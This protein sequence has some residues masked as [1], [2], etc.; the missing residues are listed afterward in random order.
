M[1]MSDLIQA[2]EARGRDNE[3][4]VLHAVAAAGADGVTSSETVA[5]T[6]LAERTVRDVI[7]RLVAQRLAVRATSRRVVA[8]PAGQAEAGAG[9]PGLAM[10]AAL[11]AALDL[12]P[13]EPMKAFVRLLLSGVVARHHL[14]WQLLAATGSVDGFASFVAAGPTKTGKTAMAKLVCQAFGLIEAQAIRTA[15]A[16]TEKSLWARRAPQPGGGYRLEPSDT[17]GRPFLCI[18]EF[19]KAPAELRSHLV[20]LAQGDALAAGEGDQLLEVAP[21]ALFCLNGSAD[22]V[23]EA[24]R[25]RS[26]V[27]DLNPLLPLLGDVH[28]A[29]R[30]LLGGA[31]PRLQLDWLAPPGPELADAEREL[32]LDGL[33][34]GLTEPGWRWADERAI[35]RLALGRA[36]L[37][38]SDPAA[39]AAATVADYL[40]CARTVGEARPGL[41]AVLAARLAGSSSLLPVPVRAEAELAQRANAS[42]RRQAEEI[43]LVAVR[44]AR[45]EQLHQ[46]EISLRQVPVKDRPPAAGLRAALREFRTRIQAQRSAAG[47]EEVWELAEPVLAQVEALAERI[48]A[49]REQ[50]RLERARQADEAA[51]TRA[52]EAAHRR[53]WAQ[54][55]RDRRALE[56]THNRWRAQRRAQL[57]RLYDRVKPADN[58]VTVLVEAGCLQRVE[59]HERHEQPHWR[60]VFRSPGQRR[61]PA[62]VVT[63]T[64]VDY[65]DVTGTAH[66][67]AELARPGTPAVRA[68]IERAAAAAG[69]TLRP[70]KGLRAI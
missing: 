44:A 7:A 36:G 25:R 42:Q 52:A 19:D 35:E 17:L 6:G 29:W 24:Y 15:I 40:S 45:A 58:W 1:A 37:T 64:V 63:K 43:A 57:Q 70:P 59:R 2:K 65:L 51:R 18:D 60:D 13:A 20:L 27:L 53:R 8:T 61:H 55:E 62:K 56:R 3:L 50:G 39:A 16:E 4:R 47:L 68:V 5:V 30:L 21:T 32:L 38:G 48:A 9:L 11:D 26:V 54:A 12:L 31:V 14:R 28:R 23:H 69:V 49:E 22:F 46:A 34:Q 66:P 67:A 41:P 33:R 10:T